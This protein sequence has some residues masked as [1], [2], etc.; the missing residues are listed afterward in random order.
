MP[1]ALPEIKLGDSGQ[2]LCKGT[3]QNFLLLPNFTW[4]LHFVS[5][6][7]STIVAFQTLFSCKM[8]LTVFWYLDGVEQGCMSNKW[9]KNAENLFVFKVIMK[10]WGGISCKCDLYQNVPLNANTIREIYR[11]WTI[12]EQNSIFKSFFVICVFQICFNK[13]SQPFW[14]QSSLIL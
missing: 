6:I 13:Y 11:H 7:L 14:Y 3:Y 4:F 2:K 1:I 9:V 12:R 5:Y 10:T 8:S